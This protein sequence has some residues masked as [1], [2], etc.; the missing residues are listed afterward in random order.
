M[1]IAFIKDLIFLK[2]ILTVLVKFSVKCKFKIEIQCNIERRKKNFV[3]ENCIS[4]LKMDL[5][6]NNMEARLGIAQNCTKYKQK[7]QETCSGHRL[8]FLGTDDLKTNISQNH[9]LFYLS[10]N[11]NTEIKCEKKK[12][13]L[14]SLLQIC[15]QFRFFKFLSS[16]VLK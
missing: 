1:S 2:S 11:F 16:T 3:F 5:F 15:F 13:H 7:Y 14:T 8:L 9:R 10:H 4:F 12:S 6:W